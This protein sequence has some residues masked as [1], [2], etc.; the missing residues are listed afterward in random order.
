MILLS[1]RIH[2]K[3]VT[4]GL[5]RSGVAGASRGIKVGAT[6]PQHRSYPRYRPQTLF[7]GS[8]IGRNIRRIPAKS[9]RSGRC[10]SFPKADTLRIFP[11]SDI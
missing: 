7:R 1:R 5:T 6:Q 8:G 2:L 10:L 4:P 3:R 9:S 11:C